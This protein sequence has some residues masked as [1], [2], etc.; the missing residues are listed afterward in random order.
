[1]TLSSLSFVVFLDPLQG[2]CVM[3]AFSLLLEYVVVVGLRHSEVAFSLTLF[4]IGL[5]GAHRWGD[6]SNLLA[7]VAQLNHGSRGTKHTIKSY[8]HV[9]ERSEMSD[10]NDG[11]S[12]EMIMRGDQ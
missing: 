11:D 12:K 4:L 2:M 1:M 5:C 3:Y 6:N 8:V 9:N 10:M 7:Y